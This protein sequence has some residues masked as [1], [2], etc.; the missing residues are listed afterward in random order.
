MEV[1]E[2][3]KARLGA[4]LMPR[5]YANDP[6][7]AAKRSARREVQNEGRVGAVAIDLKGNLGKTGKCRENLGLPYRW[8]QIDLTDLIITVLVILHL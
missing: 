8:C 2:L 7:N 6:V 5:T 4:S 3:L 1:A